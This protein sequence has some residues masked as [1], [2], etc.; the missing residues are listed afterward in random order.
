MHTEHAADAAPGRTVQPLFTAEAVRD[1]LRAADPEY[2]AGFDAAEWEGIAER[3][4][5]LARLA[6]RVSGRATRPRRE[7]GAGPS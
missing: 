3:M 4:S 6:W 5:A 2:G 7:R 1:R